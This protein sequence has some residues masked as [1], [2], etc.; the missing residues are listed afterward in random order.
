MS[1]PQDAVPKT[2]TERPRAKSVTNL[3]AVTAQVILEEA[4]KRT[5]DLGAENSKEVQAMLASLLEEALWTEEEFN[6]VLLLDI[7]SKGAP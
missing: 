3:K 2:Q 6:E 1:N 7:I 4:R 5:K